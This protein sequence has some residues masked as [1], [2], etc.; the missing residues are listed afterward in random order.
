MESDEVCLISGRF[1]RPHCGHIATIRSLG[2]RFKKVTVVVLDHSEQMYPLAI[3]LEMLHRCLDEIPTEDYEII[4]NQFHFGT[5]S[6]D[7]LLKFEFDVYAAG[8]MEVL[9]HIE[10]VYSTSL[11]ATKKRNIRTI[12]V[13]RPF[14]QDASTERLGRV[15]REMR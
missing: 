12:W 6:I 8:N 9:K 11:S 4:V 2:K 13:D 15:V 14:E 1:D 5:I 3:R 10:A 7:E